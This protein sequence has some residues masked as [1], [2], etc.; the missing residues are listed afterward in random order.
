MAGEGVD[1]DVIAS[2]DVSDQS[3]HWERAQK[4]VAIAQRYLELRQI[5]PDG[6]LAHRQSVLSLIESWEKI[7]QRRR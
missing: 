2:L 4:F 7:H 6:T 5:T 1:P 3:G